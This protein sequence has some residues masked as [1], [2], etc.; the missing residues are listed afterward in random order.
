LSN[1]CTT[2]D[3]RRDT[4]LYLCTECIIELD[5]LLKDVPALVEMLDGPITMTA[6]TK[7][8][9]MGNGAGHPGSKPPINLDALLLK[10]W[11]CRLPD[12]AHG[13]AMDNPNAGQTLYMARIW[14]KQAR[15]LVWGPEDK[16]VFGQCGE[17]L[18]DGEAP[19]LCYGRLIADPYDNS[20]KCPDCGTL[21]EIADILDRLR[22]KARGQPMTPRDARE[23]L[24]NKAKVIIQKKDFENWVMLGRIPY[25]LDRVTTDIKARKIYYPGDVLNVFQDMRAR[26]RTVA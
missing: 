24:R 7:G 26:K 23:Y 10:A 18:E 1:E 21:H 5:G 4:T 15:E 14:V 16:R 12:R 6:V 22:E 8:P 13:E 3:C 19:T 2:E 25:V 11:L 20:V 9:G 17:P